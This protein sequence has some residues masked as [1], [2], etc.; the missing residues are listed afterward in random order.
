MLLPNATIVEKVKYFGGNV[1]TGERLIKSD[2]KKL[3]DYTSQPLSDEEE[4]GHF[5]LRP[6]AKF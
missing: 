6:K 1:T 2:K 3:F 5:F 4:M